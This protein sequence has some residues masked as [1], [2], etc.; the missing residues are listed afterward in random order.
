MNPQVEEVFK[1]LEHLAKHRNVETPQNKKQMKSLTYTT[2]VMAGQFLDFHL[3]SKKDTME[4]SIVWETCFSLFSLNR[5][6]VPYE[7]C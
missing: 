5:F 2:L 6:S 3:L 7:N 1:Q 4:A